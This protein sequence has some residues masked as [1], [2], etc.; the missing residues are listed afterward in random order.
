MD[1]LHTMLRGLSRERKSQ[2]VR[3]TT[4]RTLIAQLEQ[5]ARPLARR[6][7]VGKRVRTSTKRSRKS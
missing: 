4:F 5:A 3:I 6:P 1:T 2:P 7:S